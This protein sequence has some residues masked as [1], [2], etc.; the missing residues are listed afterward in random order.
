MR[1]V[2]TKIDLR[3]LRDFLRLP[4]NTH[5]T[6]VRADP[7]NTRSCILEL[8]GSGLPDGDEI[9]AEYSYHIT[10]IPKFE[11]WRSLEEEKI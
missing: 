3:L 6:G 8:E 11:K 9:T 10:T 4:Q 1:Q 2:I 5:I 7:D